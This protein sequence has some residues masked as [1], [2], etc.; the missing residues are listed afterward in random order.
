MADYTTPTGK[1]RLLIADLADPPLL[2]EEVL[3]GYL[4]LNES[5]DAQI[6]VLRAAADALDAIATSETLISKKI[7]T[8]DLTTDGPAVAADL[9]KRAAQLRHQAIDKEAELNSFFGV[10]PLGYPP[11]HEAEEARW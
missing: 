2:S 7:R 11:S 9:R 10:E 6:G 5:E 4:A 1:V 3:Q 8:Q